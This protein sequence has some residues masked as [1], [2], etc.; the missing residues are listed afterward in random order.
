[1]RKGIN[2]SIIIL[3]LGFGFLTPV[4]NVLGTP[5]SITVKSVVHYLDGYDLVFQVEL[6]STLTHE[7][8]NF[9]LVSKDSYVSVDNNPMLRWKVNQISRPLTSNIP[10]V[11][12]FRLFING[13]TDLP[14]VYSLFARKGTGTD[15]IELRPF[16]QEATGSSIQSIYDAKGDYGIQT[17]LDLEIDSYN[18]ITNPIYKAQP[19]TVRTI[20]L[21]Y[22]H[23]PLGP[24]YMNFR[25]DS[26]TYG[27][28][29]IT[30]SFVFSSDFNTGRT[31]WT[32]MPP[33]AVTSVDVTIP[34]FGHDYDKYFAFNTG[35]WVLDRVTASASGFYTIKS[36]PKPFT[37]NVQSGTHPVLVAHLMDQPFRNFI[38]SPWMDED[39]FFDWLENLEFYMYNWLGSM[40]C[41]LDDFDINFESLELSWS[42][43]T[44]DLETLY[45]DLDDDAG[46][47][48]GLGHDWKNDGTG[49]D[50]RNNGFDMLFGHSWVMTSYP[51]TGM[52]YQGSN[53]A[54]LMKGYYKYGWL[55]VYVNVGCGTLHEVLHLYW[56]HTK[57]PL[58]DHVGVPGYIMSASGGVL[59][60]HPDTETTL[61]NEI[62]RFDF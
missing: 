57:N 53:W 62:G 36:T 29:K 5:D 14:A 44:T 22:W 35:N 47:I 43:Q 4:W 18:I 61:N 23:R 38:N 42:P 33:P 10:A 21:N 17:M 1:M 20:L 39:T 19:F 9:T 27:D 60:M 25:F 13:S 46:S 15:S 34:L 3:F 52:A 59:V 31:I 11:V 2:S 37:V 49:T 26:S 50:S 41:L 24:I 48:L 30:D 51:A 40:K 55:P 16:I 12:E 8:I 28:P 6:E 7:D 58:H 32:A 45:Y 54:L 56:C